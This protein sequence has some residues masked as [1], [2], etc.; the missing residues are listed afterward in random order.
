M[1]DQRPFA[2]SYS[3]FVLP[4]PVFLPVIFFWPTAPPSWAESISH[5]ILSPLSLPFDSLNSFC[6]S[7]IP[8]SPLSLFF[9]PTFW[10]IPFNVPLVLTI[11]RLPFLEKYD[12]NPKRL[13]DRRFC[14]GL[15]GNIFLAM[16]D[17]SQKDFTTTWS[18]NVLPFFGI[19]IVFTGSSASRYV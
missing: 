9:L 14:C 6:Y 10:K 7:W 17:S 8:F 11:C 3:W 2:P 19:I 4:F 12:G 5:P 16:I 13:T 18:W 1:R 15:P